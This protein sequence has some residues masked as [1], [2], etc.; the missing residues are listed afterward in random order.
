MFNNNMWM[1]EDDPFFD[2]LQQPQMSSIMPNDQRGRRGEGRRRESFQDP[3]QSMMVNMNSM[4]SGLQSQMRDFENNPNSHG[5]TSSM[6]MSYQSD[7]KSK[8]KIMQACTSTRCAPG[9][10]K[11]T[12]RSYRDSES[13]VEKMAIGHHIGRRGHEIEKRRQRGGNI[14]EEQRFY[15]MNE[16]DLPGFESEWKQHTNSYSIPMQRSNRLS[17]TRPRNSSRDQAE[18]EYR[19]AGPSKSGRQRY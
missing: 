2:G 15:E 14:E 9:D 1:F 8:P 18:L 19:P 7:G 6:M 12:R 3:F 5:Y 10:V 16:Q 4:M 11:E 17:G 13:G